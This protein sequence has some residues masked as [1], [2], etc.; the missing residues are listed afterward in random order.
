MNVTEAIQS[1]YYVYR[2][3]GASKTPIFGS[4]KA[5]TC[6]AIMN[7]KKNEWANDSDQTWVSNFSYVAPNEVGLVATAGTTTLTGTN[8][9]FTDYQV[10]DKIT[11][12][13]ETVRTIDA[14]TSDTSLTVTVA[15]TNTAANL[16]HKRTI[17]IKSGVTSYNLNRNFLTPSDKVLVTT[18][19]N[20]TLKLGLANP[21]ERE[22]D[23]Y[24]SSRN[25]KVLTFVNDITATD[26]KVGGTLNVPAYYLPADMVLSTD[27]VP[28]DNPEWLVYIVASE[29]ARNDPAKEDQ[30]ATLVGMANDL[31]SKMCSSNLNIGFLNGG[32]V[33]NN[34]PQISNDLDE[35]WTL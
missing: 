5:N 2:G 9:Y 33:Y 20:N 1:I 17:I 25:P 11:V 32:T 13:G 22:S 23:C 35:D 31:Y 24:L 30:F 19:L 27:L 7:R 34:M 4:E 14:I 8:T 18:T 6:L 15:F 26:Q 10:G 3:K 21:Q 29:L 12:Y 16:T 28:I